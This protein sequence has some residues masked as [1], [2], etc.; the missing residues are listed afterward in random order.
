[1][2]RIVLEVSNETARKWRISSQKRKERITQEIDLK[3][4]KE[5]SDSREEFLE[6][7]TNMRKTMKERGLTE[8]I[9]QEILND[10]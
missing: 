1:M 6:F 8:E 2:E 5:L 7:L 4:A 9:L 10:D 3:L